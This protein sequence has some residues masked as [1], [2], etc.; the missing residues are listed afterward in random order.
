MA[1]RRENASRSAKILP[2]IELDRADANAVAVQLPAKPGQ[3]FAAIYQV[4]PA[5]SSLTE[6]LKISRITICISISIYRIATASAF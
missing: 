1:K 4:T 6:L 3:V 5:G 2:P